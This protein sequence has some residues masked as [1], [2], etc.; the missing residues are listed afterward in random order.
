MAPRATSLP[1]KVRGLILSMAMRRQNNFSPEIVC[2][3]KTRAQAKV[4]S[5]MLK[6]TF[7]WNGS[8]WGQGSGVPKIDNRSTTT[9]NLQYS[10]TH[11]QANPSV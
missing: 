4:V 1:V 3:E 6:K 9:T 5:G 7:T 8:Q 10:V 11:D 2:P